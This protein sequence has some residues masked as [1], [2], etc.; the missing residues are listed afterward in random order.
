MVT[1]ENN[2]KRGASQVKWHG[3]MHAEELVIRGGSLGEYE[4]EGCQPGD[5]VWK[6]ACR[7]VGYQ[8]Q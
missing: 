4:E 5:M 1:W 6:N 3:R 7:R 8:M 2:R